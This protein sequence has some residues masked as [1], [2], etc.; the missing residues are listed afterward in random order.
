MGAT[1]E[2]CLIHEL[3]R[4][5]FNVLIVHNILSHEPAILGCSLVAVSGYWIGEKKGEI[6]P[7]KFL[8]VLK[9][10]NCSLPYKFKYKLQ[11]KPV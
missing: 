4:L 3:R 7:F 2:E 11:N 9:F 10:Q 1:F 6:F 5:R 8:A